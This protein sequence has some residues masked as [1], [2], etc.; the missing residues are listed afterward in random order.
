MKRLL[1]PIEPLHYRCDALQ[2][3]VQAAVK[4]NDPLLQQAVISCVVHYANIAWGYP[5]SDSLTTAKAWA[6]GC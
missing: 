2:L 4:N 5:N 1:T 3:A 6:R